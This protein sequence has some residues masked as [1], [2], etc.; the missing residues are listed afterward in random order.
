MKQIKK[1]NVASIF[2]A[3]GKKMSIWYS[4]QMWTNVI[5]RSCLDTTLLIPI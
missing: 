4:Q 5:Y 2:V 3:A 1:V